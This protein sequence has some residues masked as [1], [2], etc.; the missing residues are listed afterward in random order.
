MSFH[1]SSLCFEL[2]IGETKFIPSPLSSHPLQAYVKPRKAAAKA[3]KLESVE[4]QK[5]KEDEEEEAKAAA[6]DSRIVKGESEAV[7]RKTAKPN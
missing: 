6:V 4:K 5:K 7:K 3:K 2:A 1:C